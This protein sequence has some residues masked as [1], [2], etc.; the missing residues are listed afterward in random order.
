MP[1]G[2]IVIFF[3]IFV[4]QLSKLLIVE[5]FVHSKGLEVLPY[6]SYG[7]LELL[8]FL[9]I[10]L[11]W[12]TGISFSMFSS[13]DNLTMYIILAIQVSIVILLL[14]WMKNSKNMLQFF[15]FGLIIG[16]AFGNIID[17]VHYGAVVDFIDFF[18]NQYHFPTFNFAD[19]AISVGCFLWL[20]ENIFLTKNQI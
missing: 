4:D 7:W 17:R 3:I 19:I 1:I 11:V 13:G 16:G 5:W 9:N 8:P 18:Y 10:R 15:I 20:V 12:N 2:L 6:I 14:F